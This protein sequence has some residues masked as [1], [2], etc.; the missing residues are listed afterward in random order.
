MT[1][2]GGFPTLQVEEW[3][4]CGLVPVVGGHLDLDVVLLDVVEKLTEEWS[5]KPCLVFSTWRVFSSWWGSWSRRTT[6]SSWR[7]MTSRTAR[8]G[9][10]TFVRSSGCWSM[11]LG[12]GSTMRTMVECWS[13]IWW[14]EVA[15]RWWRSWNWCQWRWWKLVDAALDTGFYRV[16]HLLHH[17][18]RV[19]RYTGSRLRGW[20]CHRCRC[21]WRW[22][23]W[24]RSRRSGSGLM[25]RDKLLKVLD[26]RLGLW[27]K[28]LV[29]NGILLSESGKLRLSLSLRLSLRLLVHHVTC[30]KLTLKS[31]RLR[32]PSIVPHR[33]RD[34]RKTSREH[35]STVRLVDCENWFKKKRCIHI[36][37]QIP[38]VRLNGQSSRQPYGQ[39][40]VFRWI[41]CTVE[42]HQSNQKEVTTPVKHVLLPVHVKMAASSLL[43]Q[44]EDCYRG[45]R[46]CNCS[47]SKKGD[48]RD[49]GKLFQHKSTATGETRKKGR[50]FPLLRRIT[51]SKV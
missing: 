31:H 6:G 16:L 2:V 40:S 50:Q 38:L 17:L 7:F 9:D 49:S 14:M 30:A 42:P 46:L 32:T 22:R 39:L 21:F 13:I 1:V 44:K 45:F 18:F 5:T 28:L 51:N 25:E 35:G 11:A 23:C 29:E 24:L 3:L 20:R 15:G 37:V 43:K 27:C 12:P 34:V 47:P 36:N 33:I 4:V 26:V 19:E 48:P 10:S 41:T 8:N